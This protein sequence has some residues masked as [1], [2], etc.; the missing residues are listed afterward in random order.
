VIEDIASYTKSRVIRTKVGSV[1]VS[2]RMVPEKA[3]VG[4]EE[5]G[6]FMYGK[7]N[8]VRDGCMT[9]ALMLDLLAQSGKSLTEELDQLPE[10]FTTKDKVACTKQQA[11][12]VIAHLKKE[13][14]NYDTTDGI[15]IILDEKNWVMVRPS[16]TEPIAR[17]YAQ[18]DSQQGLDDLMS[19]YLKRVRAILA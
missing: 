6:G 17:I 10:S 1:E 18:S 14:Q 16:G 15:K 12:K 4:F 7:H 9:L 11:K 2:R 5:N 8:Q 13:H 3:L 19:K